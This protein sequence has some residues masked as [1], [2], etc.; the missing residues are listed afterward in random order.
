MAEGI[1]D[2][3]N[4]KMAQAIRTITVEQG[5]RAAR[6]RA[7]WRLAAP[8]RCTRSSW[9][10]SW[11]RRGDRAALSRRVF[12]LGHAADQIRKDFSRAYFQLA[13]TS[14][15]SD[16]G[17]RLRRLEADGVSTL[18]RRGRRP[19]PAAWTHSVDIRYAGQ[20]Y[21][22]TVPADGRRRAGSRRT[23]S[24][25]SPRGSTRRTRRRLRPRQSGAP[26]E[27][28]DRCARPRSAISG[29][30]SRRWPIAQVGGR[31]RTTDT[32]GGVRTA[33]DRATPWSR[34][35]TTS[36]PAH[37]STV[38]PSSSRTTATTVV[39]PAHSSSSSTSSARWI[40]DRGARPD[41]AVEIDPVTSEIIRNAFNSPP[42][43]R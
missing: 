35:A 40:I 39:P 27:F 23:S 1:C 36:S 13:R 8:D 42:P 29:R 24:R 11:H 17:R 18:G 31:F 41:M 43:T 9:P 6:L 32:P 12:R 5:H 28:V 33:R 10:R 2:V 21:T 14:T 15:D 7:S 34:G 19:R 26:I 25:R 16:V 30:P 4:A 22:L 20:E 37:A 38:P 3:V